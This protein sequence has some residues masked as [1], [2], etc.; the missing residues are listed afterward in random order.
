MNGVKSKK[1]IPL[2]SIY[3]WFGHN[4]IEWGRNKKN[5]FNNVEVFLLLAFQTCNGRN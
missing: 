3:G 2:I 1:S 4:S 5:L